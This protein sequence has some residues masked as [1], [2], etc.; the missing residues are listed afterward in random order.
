MVKMSLVQSFQPKEML[1]YKNYLHKM[2]MFA[3]KGLLVF[4]V[5]NDCEMLTL[6]KH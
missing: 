3:Q 5:G 6:I 1:D 2:G 4:K